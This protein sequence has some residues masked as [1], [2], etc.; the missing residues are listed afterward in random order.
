MTI[1]ITI[2]NVPENVRDALRSRAAAQGRS[3]QEFLRA[4]L[5]R[6]ASRPSAD[7][8]VEQVRKRKRASRGRVA[9]GLILGHRNAERR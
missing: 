5:T 3:M 7:M 8:W 6:L 4:E 2:R 9:A 1:Q